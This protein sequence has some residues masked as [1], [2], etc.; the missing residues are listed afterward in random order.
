MRLDDLVSYLDEY[1][2]IRQGGD[3]ALAFNGLQVE[4]AGEVRRIAAAVDACQAVFD[5]AA[6][7]GA[8]LL[9]VH[10]GLF[11]GG[12]QP[13]T[14]PHY[15]RVSALVRAGMALY[16]AHLPLDRHPEVGNN[17]VLARLLGMQVTGWWGEYKGAP[18]AV[19]GELELPRETLTQRIAAALGPVPRLIPGGPGS[20]KQVGIVTGA[21]G[22]MI[23]EA[24]AAGLDTLI[25][26]EG[27][28]HSFFD[29]EELG[30]NVFY[31][32]HYATET[33]GVTALAEHLAGRFTLP[34]SFIDHPTGL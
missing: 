19:R 21:G 33:V 24:K 5:R 22:S 10:H 8:D 17:V 9:I 12:L 25:T 4:N 14:G 15:R 13:L 28:H 20:T 32:G 6:A 18:I 27:K 23:R 16:G 29:A 26:G 31:A 2:Q 1:L 7:L 34:W 3:D 11:W 30:I